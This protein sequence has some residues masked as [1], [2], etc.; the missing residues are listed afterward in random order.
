M[1]VV[2]KTEIMPLKAWKD[3]PGS[4]FSQAPEKH[5][6][7]A[8]AVMRLLDLPAHILEGIWPACRG[9]AC[10]TL[11]KGLSS[12]LLPWDKSSSVCTILLRRNRFSFLVEG[13]EGDAGPLM[14]LLRVC[15]L[16]CQRGYKIRF[17]LEGA[18]DMEYLSLRDLQSQ[19]SNRTA[20]Y[21]DYVSQALSSVLIS[22]M[23][24]LCSC[25]EEES[26][27]WSMHACGIFS[28]RAREMRDFNPSAKNTVHKEIYAQILRT[29]V[30][31]GPILARSLTPVHESL[32]LMAGVEIHGGFSCTLDP[33]DGAPNPS[34]GQAALLQAIPS[35]DAPLILSQ[36]RVTDKF[37]RSMISLCPGLKSLHLHYGG[38]SHASG[39]MH[40]V[41]QFHCLEVSWGIPPSLDP[42][43]FPVSAPSCSLYSRPVLY[44]PPSVAGD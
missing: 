42:S 41:R 15:R 36:A 9:P 20:W 37:W 33:K 40:Y 32:F 43:G 25:S 13:R 27:E 38:P 7:R 4:H 39:V 26:R 10:R 6:A 30:A 23:H 12:I 8:P 1:G 16:C 22:R 11:C 18:Q 31:C 5:H 44:L 2:L 19:I 29:D 3:T 17:L 24:L 34:S 14:A 28:Q 21:T 35:F